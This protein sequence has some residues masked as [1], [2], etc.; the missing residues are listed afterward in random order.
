MPMGYHGLFH[1]RKSDIFW[2]KYGD[3]F[4]VSD[5]DVLCAFSSYKEN[6]LNSC[7][8]NFF[9]YKMGLAGVLSAWSC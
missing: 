5:P 9:L 6:K 1:R 7:K 3:I 2:K 4:L 8:C